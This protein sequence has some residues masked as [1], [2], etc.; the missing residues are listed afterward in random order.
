MAG[1]GLCW[2]R[3][4]KDRNFG[5]D[6]IQVNSKKPIAN[7]IYLELNPEASAF[8]AKHDRACNRSKKEEDVLCGDMF[9]VLSPAEKNLKELS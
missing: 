9:R 3:Y 2:T 7:G 8:A 5:Y 1:C 4:R 6:G